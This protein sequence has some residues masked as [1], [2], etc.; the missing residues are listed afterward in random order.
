MSVP[1]HCCG[2]VT[3]GRTHGA[4]DAAA[5]R[6]NIPPL[7]PGRPVHLERR[8]LR[9]QAQEEWLLTPAGRGGRRLPPPAAL[10][11]GRNALTWAGAADAAGG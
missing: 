11:G 2:A 3:G 7:I 1:S 6:T 5:H 4:Q 10:D 9:F 8:R